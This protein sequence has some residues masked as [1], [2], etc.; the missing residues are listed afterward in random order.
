MLWKTCGH[1]T[2]KLS[3]WWAHKIS[4]VPELK[5]TAIFWWA[6]LTET[7][8]S[9]TQWKPLGTT[10]TSDLGTWLIRQLLFQSLLKENVSVHWL[11]W[12]VCYTVTHGAKLTKGSARCEKIT[13]LRRLIIIIAFSFVFLF[14][15]I[16]FYVS[17]QDGSSAA[18]S[19]LSELLTASGF[20][21]CKDQS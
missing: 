1:E 12:F 15:G 2:A 18:L 7:F 20:C 13:W 10:A 3:K 19:I 14:S 4:R 5:N 17:F 6:A 16:P 21:L 11:K 9:A 8:L